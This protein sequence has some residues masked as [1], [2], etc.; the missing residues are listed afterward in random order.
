M[1][2]VLS[3]TDRERERENRDNE[4]GLEGRKVEEGWNK[5]YSERESREGRCMG[6]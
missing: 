5:R 4:R 6:R 3:E 2:I 1:H